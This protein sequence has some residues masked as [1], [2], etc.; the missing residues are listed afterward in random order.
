MTSRGDDASTS[1]IG[2]GKKSVRPR[3]VVDHT[4]S[5]KSIEQVNVREF[6]EHF[7]ISGGI[8]IRL[9]SGDPVS[10]EQEPDDAIVFSNEQF[11]VELCFPLFSPFK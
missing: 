7:R 6:R 8:P 1:A 11:N 2:K 3:K 4:E 9:L 5:G 10:T